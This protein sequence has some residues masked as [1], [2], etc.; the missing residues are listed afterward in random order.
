MRSILLLPPWGTRSLSSPLSHQGR[1]CS[2]TGLFL[3]RKRCSCPHPLQQV[4]LAGRRSWLSAGGSSMWDL[5][6]V[7]CGF[8][9]SIILSAE[10]AL[11]GMA[12]QWF[13]FSQGTKDNRTSK[14]FLTE[15]LFFKRKFTE[16][17]LQLL[18]SQGLETI[19]SWRQIQE[20]RF[21]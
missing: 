10:R 20:V 13:F 6:L 12:S 8:S 18:S 16:V 4:C 1:G 7:S 2:G 15:L 5:L 21:S 17:S 11:P 3:T 9:M 14:V 19:V